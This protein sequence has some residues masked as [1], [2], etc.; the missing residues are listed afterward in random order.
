MKRY[1]AYFYR[2]SMI[3]VAARE[4]YDYH[5][6]QWYMWLLDQGH[7]LVTATKLAGFVT[8]Q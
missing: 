2:P 4:P 6:I 5:V 8:K 7:V 1:A 3:A